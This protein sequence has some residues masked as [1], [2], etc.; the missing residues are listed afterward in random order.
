MG[1]IAPKCANSETYLVNNSK[2]RQ[3]TINMRLDK[4]QISAL[5]VKRRFPVEFFWL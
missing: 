3:T 4:N 5:E 2:I 1:L